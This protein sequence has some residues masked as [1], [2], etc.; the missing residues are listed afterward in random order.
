MR[1]RQLA[2]VAAG[3]LV[4]GVLAVPALMAPAQ[5]ATAPIIYT[6]DLGLTGS[7]ASYG[8]ERAATITFETD[9]PA[10]LAAGAKVTPT[11]TAS[12]RFAQEYI[13]LFQPSPVN[14]MGGTMTATTDTAG[15]A[16]T[17][18]LTFAQWD[19]A[20]AMGTE[21]EAFDLVGSGPWSEITGSASDIQ[22]GV[23]TLEGDLYI[24]TSFSPGNTVVPT[25]CTPD[26]GLTTVV[27]TIT[28][29]AA[30]LAT[31]AQCTLDLTESGFGGVGVYPAKVDATATVPAAGRVGTA[32]S[33]PIEATITMGDEFSTYL[34]SSP[35]YKITGSVAPKLTLGTDSASGSDIALSTWE[36]TLAP[37]SPI[38]QPVNEHVSLTGAGNATVNPTSAGNKTATLNG[39]QGAA[40]LTVTFGNATMDA[41]FDCVLD[42][43]AVLGTV[44]VAAKPVVLPPATAVKAGTKTT[45]KT[46]V[47][48]KKKTAKVTIKV[49]GKA[50]GKVKVVVKAGKKKF[51]AVTAKVK[52]GKATIKLKKLKKGKYTVTAK[53]AGDA[54][55][56]ASKGSKKF[57]VKK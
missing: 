55:H 10:G 40:A 14:R 23:S 15:T 36:R 44:G 11:L 22:L 33:I 48:A 9:A 4:G 50:S 5:A 24:G 46:K 45:V 30:A 3:T 56:K 16:G 2:G 20:G 32:T 28:P 43:P 35:V 6:C 41:P 31:N 57:T 8:G 19:R 26:S 17:A 34:K 42:T 47:N 54:K 39:L 7:F 1:F 51:K 27:D 29:G 53:Y 37:G 52:K 21:V 13:D 38:G 12:L 25:T 49:T 18:A